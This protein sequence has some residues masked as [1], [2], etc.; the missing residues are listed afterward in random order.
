MCAM[1]LPSP[2]TP[3]TSE[4]SKRVS[5]A[6]GHAA[7]APA[8]GSA[9][10]LLASCAKGDREAFLSLHERMAPRIFGMVVSVL[11]PGPRA[12]D[13]FQD[14][15]WE[16]WRRASAYNPALCSAEGWML[17]LTRSRAVDV[18]RRDRRYAHAVKTHAE[19]S[20][21]DA[22]F[23]EPVHSSPTSGVE[24]S[25]LTRLLELLPREQSVAIRLAYIQGLSR[26]QIAQALRIPVGT[27]KT[28][29]RLG[30]KAIAEHAS[31]HQEGRAGS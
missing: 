13:A 30:V 20:P 12:E 25:E 21:S 17:M 26:E 19:S 1:D 22:G 23:S 2:P 8:E 16:I 28:R 9:A 15:M 11:G 4:A 27:V 31:K 14:A 29:I 24:A 3:S 5:S 7:H 18:L 10:D 6:P